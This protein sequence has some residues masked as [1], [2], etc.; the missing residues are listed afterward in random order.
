MKLSSVLRQRPLFFSICILFFGFGGL[1]LA[2]IRQGDGIIFFSE[3]RQPFWDAFFK[4]AT[5]LAEEPV[6]ALA[7]VIYLFYRFRFAIMLPLLGIT[8]TL[9]ASG[10]K[11]T[12]KEFR[13]AKWF[14]LNRPDVVLNFVEGIEPYRAATSF[15]SGHSMAGFALFTFLCLSTPRKAGL[16][17]VFA[18]LAIG[19]AVSRI[20]L[21]Q[22]FLQDIVIGGMIGLLLG[23]FWYWL[24]IRMNGN[25]Y[26]WLDKRLQV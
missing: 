5:R 3:H 15:P 22:H 8:V 4:V 10:L 7:L 18:L 20:Y 19:V 6:F 9:V 16:Q 17:V 21:V 25:K 12:F 13:P 26:Q 23:A 24:T 14:E 1:V 2:Q 11:F